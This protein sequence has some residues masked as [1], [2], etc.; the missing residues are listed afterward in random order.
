[1][2]RYKFRKII[3]EEIQNLTE[4]KLDK[5]LIPL[6]NI[7]KESKSFEDFQNAI[8][9]EHLTDLSNRDFQ[10]FGRAFN[11]DPEINLSAANI[12]DEYGYD[13]RVSYPK[14]YQQL[15]SDSNKITIYRAVPI[16]ELKLYQLIQNHMKY[17]LKHGKVPSDPLKDIKGK[18][19]Y[20]DWLWEERRK[21]EEKGVDEQKRKIDVGDYVA[22]DREYAVTHGRSQYD[23]LY[24]IVSKT[25]PKKDVI[26]DGADFEEWVYSPQAHRNTVASLEDFYEKVKTGQYKI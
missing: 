7:A 24:E 20:Y 6:Y 22:I 12:L 15:A 18:S 26:W 5:E 16:S 10:R 2:D 13:I 9:Q 4:Q 23:K 25:V 11:I 3:L 19:D 8:T 21:L 17:I 14:V 1:M